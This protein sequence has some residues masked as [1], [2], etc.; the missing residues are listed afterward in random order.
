[1]R[2]GKKH[3]EES[4]HKMSE[5]HKGLK[6]SEETI[7]KMSEAHKGKPSGIL[8]KSWGHHTKE[9]RRKLSETHKGEKNY[10][11]KGGIESE[12]RRIRKGIEFRLWREAVFTRDNWTCQRCLQR[13]RELHPHHIQNFAQFPELRFAIDNGITF[14]K[15]CHQEFHKKYR[16]KNNTKEQLEEFLQ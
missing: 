10:R 2:I 15:S 16:E 4:K 7:K 14:C 3:L 8:G 5:S 6:H 13:G 12:N 1:M 11:W 9:T